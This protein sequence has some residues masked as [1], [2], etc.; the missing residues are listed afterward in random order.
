[1]TAQG[2]NAGVNGF[3]EVATNAFDDTIG[4]KWLDLTTNYPST[5]Q[6]WIQYQYPNDIRW[7][8]S[9][10]TITS[11][12]DAMI[13]PARNPANWRLRGSNNGGASWATLD[14]QT[15]QTFSANFQ[16]LTYPIANTNAYNIYKVQIDSVA[17]P[18]QATCMQLDELEFQAVPPAYYY[19]WSFG[20][21]AT[22]TSRN[23]Q[24][25]YASNG[26]YTAVLI[27]SDGLSS[28]TNTALVTVATPAL[29]ILPGLPGTLALGWPTWATDYQLYTTTNLTPPV[30]WSLA[31]NEVILIN[32]T[33]TVSVPIE[34]GSRFFQLRR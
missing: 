6:S 7:A 9:Q 33:N 30:T 12:N 22:S 13:Y 1:M 18:S 15:N 3:W 2:E 32:D 20:D 16:K 11:A 27:V 23:P 21:G 8:V 5:R 25:T 17:N 26:T 4:T 29:T 19:S 28:A 24:H 34:D 14:I 10:Y 31:T